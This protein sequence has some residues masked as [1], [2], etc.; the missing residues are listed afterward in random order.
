MDGA[1]RRRTQSGRP[2]AAHRGG[3]GGLG[4]VRRNGGFVEA[5]ITHGDENGRSRWPDEFG[6]LEQLGLA[7]LDGMQADIEKYGMDAEWERT[8]MLTVATEPHQLRWLRVAAEEGE[9]R[10]LD[11]A[12]IR[13]E[14]HSPT[15]LG[16]LFTN[17]CAIV[18]PARL[19]FGWPAPVRRT[20]WR[21]TSTPR[22]HRST[23]IAAGP[24]VPK[25]G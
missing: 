8:G 20:V 22:R 4:G 21:S 24:W 16:A 12:Q 18:N 10:L 13:A 7:N 25:P 23:P 11:E 15:Y 19:V 5:S 17:T 14:V 3:T 6:R 1:A 9:G 2:G